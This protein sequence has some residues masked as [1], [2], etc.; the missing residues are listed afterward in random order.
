MIIVRT[1]GLV[2]TLIIHEP[3]MCTYIGASVDHDVGGHAAHTTR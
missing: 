2:I 1:C 3:S